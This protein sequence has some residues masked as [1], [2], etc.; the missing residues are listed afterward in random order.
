MAARVFI[1]YRRR[2]G[3]YQADRIYKA[4]CQVVARENNFYGFQLDHPGR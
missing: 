4:F 2:D 1:S 3:L